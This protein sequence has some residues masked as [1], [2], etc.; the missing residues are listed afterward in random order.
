MI[1]TV[2]LDLQVPVP[3]DRLAKIQEGEASSESVTR[4]QEDDKVAGGSE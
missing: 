3:L 1:T 4:G 2:P